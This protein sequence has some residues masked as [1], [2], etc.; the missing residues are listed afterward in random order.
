M[1]L[2]PPRQRHCSH[3]RRRRAS[4]RPSRAPASTRARRWWSSS[5]PPTTSKTSSPKCPTAGGKMRLRRSAPRRYQTVRHAIDYVRSGTGAWSASSTTRRERRG[6]PESGSPDRF[7]ESLS[8]ISST[9]T[10]WRIALPMAQ[11]PRGSIVT[12][13]PRSPHRAR[14]EPPLRRRQ[15]RPACL[16]SR[17]GC[18]ACPLFACAPMRSCRLK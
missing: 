16:D 8:R 14:E 13:A 4:A 10:P 15:R 6:R 3:R 12:S 17:M 2:R 9:T 18:R 11:G 1:D 7:V 5:R